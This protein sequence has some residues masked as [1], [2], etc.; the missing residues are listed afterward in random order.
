M[1][2]ENLFRKVTGNFD[3]QIMVSMILVCVCGLVVLHSAGFDPEAGESAQ[4]KQQA[5]WMIIGFIAFLACSFMSSGFL[6]RWAYVFYAVGLCLL[7]GVFFTGIVAG[8]ARRWIDLGHVRVQPSEFMKLAVIILFAR[9]F[10]SDFAPRNG[11]TFFRL[12]LPL[13]LMLVPAILIIKQPDLGTGLVV[14]MI[15][16][17]MLLFAGVRTATILRLAIIGMLG[18]GAVLGKGFLKGTQTQLRFLPEQTT[19]FIFSVLAEEWGFAGSV[20]LLLLY[21]SLIFRLLSIAARCPERFPAFVTFGVASLLFWQVTVNVGMV[22]GVLPVV[23]ITLPLLS[24]G[25]SSVL[26]VMAG[27]GIASGIGSRRFLFA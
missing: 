13:A 8:G 26:T 22:I 23:G 6:K 19:D 21:A 9:F 16:G 1:L 27:L 20:V 15:G 5:V 3:W 4:M 24:Y 17:S 14:L 18:S 7:V 2:I 12:L 25:G 10:S 11:Y